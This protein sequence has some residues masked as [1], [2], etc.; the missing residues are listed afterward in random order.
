[1]DHASG[2]DI[3]DLAIK[4]D[5]ITLKAKF[6]LLDINKLVNV[7]TILNNSKRKVDHL[8]VDKLQTVPVDLKN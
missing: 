8:D 6:D 4:N 5:F 3:S 7:P 1:M 2:V